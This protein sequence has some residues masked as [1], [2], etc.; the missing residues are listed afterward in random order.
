LA[1]AQE[2]R[3]TILAQDAEI[4]RLKARVENLTALGKKWMQCMSGQRKEIA[5]L[6]AEVERLREALEA[7]NAAV[8]IDVLMEGPRYMGVEP[9]RGREAW[10][11]ARTALTP[12]QETRA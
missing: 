2:A 9:S 1:W 10:E 12:S 8:R 11:L 5:S 3:D 4:A 6:K 7:W